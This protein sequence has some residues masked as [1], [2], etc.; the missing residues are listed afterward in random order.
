MN[1]TEL[2]I[3]IDDSPL[4]L[5]VKQEINPPDLW[6]AKLLKHAN[7]AKDPKTD[8]SKRKESL[9]TIALMLLD[10]TSETKCL[11][12]NHQ[13]MVI[14]HIKDRLND[15]PIVPEDMYYCD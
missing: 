10:Y 14:E 2:S 5:M 4:R 1:T 8:H 7:R 12:N 15:D 9:M 11:F 3:L 13:Q 6:Y